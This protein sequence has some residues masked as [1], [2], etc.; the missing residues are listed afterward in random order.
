MMHE[1][2]PVQTP[3]HTHSA[4]RIIIRFDSLRSFHRAR[5]LAT[6]APKPKTEKCSATQ[7]VCACVV[8]CR[9]FTCH[10]RLFLSLF[11]FT[12]SH[13]IH[14]CSVNA[15]ELARP[16]VPHASMPGSSVYYLFSYFRT[17]QQTTAH[18]RG[19]NTHT[20]ISSRVHSETCTRLPAV[21][22][23][24]CKRPH[25]NKHT[26]HIS[27][28]VQYARHRHNG[29]ISINYFENGSDDN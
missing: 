24:V 17:S 18:A 28:C 5:A 16:F 20:H 27:C 21:H 11:V 7:I 1:L 10:T 4:E 6:T 23:S 25:T 3:T 15:C 29:H 13:I 22:E 9:T 19:T 26:R 2:Y 14:T 12:H 8:L